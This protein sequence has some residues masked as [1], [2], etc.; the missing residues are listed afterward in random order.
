MSTSTFKVPMKGKIIAAYLK[1]F[2]KYRRMGFFYLKN[3]FPFQKYCCF[4]YAK[5]ESDDVR[6]FATK[7]IKY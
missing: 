7:I 3:L 4:H 1:D 6:R 2:S 5:Q